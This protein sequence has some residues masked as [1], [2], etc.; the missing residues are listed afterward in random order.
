MFF[1]LN[2]DNGVNSIRLFAK[3]KASKCWQR[4]NK[5]SSIKDCEKL[6]ETLI[7]VAKPIWS[8]VFLEVLT[9]QKEWHI[10]M[11][12]CTNRGILMLHASDALFQKKRR[13]RTKS[14]WDIF[15][16]NKKISFFK[17][18][19][20]NMWWVTIRFWQ[21][22]LTVFSRTSHLR[23]MICTEKQS[24]SFVMDLP[25]LLFFFCFLFFTFIFLL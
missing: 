15:C 23:K 8:Y 13:R 5:N 14:R 4:R 3:S 19:R 25:Q 22:K 1:F 17:T 18:L 21:Q 9:G 7:F 24:L 20:E 11:F 2:F 10:M 6:K 16:D 12:R